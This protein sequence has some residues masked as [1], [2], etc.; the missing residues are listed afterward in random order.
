MRLTFSTILVMT[1]SVGSSELLLD[2][3]GKFSTFSKFSA[4]AW[5]VSGADMAFP[6]LLAFFP[7]IIFQCL[8][9][10][11]NCKDNTKQNDKLL[12]KITKLDQLD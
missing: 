6:D 11:L 5:A 8:N 3:V 9:L 2:S 4:A 1:C 12:I 7:G 10:T